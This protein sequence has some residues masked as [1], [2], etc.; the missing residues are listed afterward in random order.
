MYIVNRSYV[1]T[2][3]DAGGG[4]KTAKPRK[5]KVC[6]IFNGV[7]IPDTW[8]LKELKIADQN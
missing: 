4:G 6:S 2:R 8:S 3:S 7:I 1:A 5:Y